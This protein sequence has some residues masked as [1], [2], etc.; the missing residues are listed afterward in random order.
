M[1]NIY[2]MYKY[3]FV[4]NIN[5]RE[6]YPMIKEWHSK[7]EEIKWNENESCE[8]IYGHNKITITT[9]PGDN[10]G[11]RKWIYKK[12][13]SNSIENGIVIEKN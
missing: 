9:I 10:Q 7:F 4:P 12:I 1:S 6:K 13:N 8:F 11:E 2:K 3:F 5:M